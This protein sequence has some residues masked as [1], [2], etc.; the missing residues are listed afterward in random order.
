MKT[1]NTL[2]VS[3]KKWFRPLATA[4]LALFL[5]MGHAAA[6]PSM[7]APD[8]DCDQ[9]VISLFS[10]SYTDVPVDTWL[11]P[12]SPPATTLTDLQIDGNDTKLYQNVDFLG[13]EMFGTPVDASA[14]TTFNVDVWTSNMTTFRVKLVDFSGP[15]TE[16]EIAFTPTQSGWNTFS[17]PMVDFSNPALVTNPAFTLGSASQISQLIFSGLP[18]GSGDFYVDNIY[19]STCGAPPPPPST[20]VD[21]EFCVDLGCFPVSDAVAIAGSFNNFNPGADF[22]MQNM[23]NRIYCKTIGLNPGNYDFKFFFAQEQFENLDVADDC[24]VSSPGAPTDGF[25]R[26]ITVEEGMPQSV[27]F[28]WETC[29]DNCPPPP[30]ADIEFCLDLSP[31]SV[32]DAPAVAGTFN[33]FNPGIDFLMED[34]GNGIYCKTV[35]VPAGEQDF[36][37][38]F[39]QEQFEDLD[40]SEDC[41]VNSPTAPNGGLA[42]RI[43]VVQDVPQSLIYGWETCAESNPPAPSCP[44]PSNVTVSYNCDGVV[45]LDWDIEDPYNRVQNYTVDI[46]NGNQP[47]VDFVNMQSTEL[48]IVAGTLTPGTTYNYAIT[49]NCA[50][51]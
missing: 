31:F 41:I 26:R 37:F 2:F 10:N 6:Q 47:V 49:A 30:T 23:G 4:C 38:F 19:F 14:M 9:D 24:V 11:T 48:T 29:E 1:T 16:G 32:V 8:P 17:I 12:W 34:M 20:E 33:G 25:A 28:G 46:E 40:N 13:I 18:T 3:P 22:L 45:V 35:T 42:R 51:S 15:Q 27:T 50:A 5:F 36:M 44:A 43:T 21:V 7:A 39:A